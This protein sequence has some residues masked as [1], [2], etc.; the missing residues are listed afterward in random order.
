MTKSIK[1][2]NQNIEDQMKYRKWMEGQFFYHDNEKKRQN[3]RNKKVFMSNHQ[4]RDHDEMLIMSPKITVFE[5]SMVLAHPSTNWS[6][7]KTCQ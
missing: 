6:V 7:Y 1:N 2:N 5:S 4:Q 3:K